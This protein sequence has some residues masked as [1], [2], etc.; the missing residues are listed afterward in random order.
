[1]AMT[2]AIL[3]DNADIADMQIYQQAGKIASLWWEGF[4][5]MKYWLRVGSRQRLMAGYIRAY[6]YNDETDAVEVVKVKEN[7]LHKWDARKQTLQM[8]CDRLGVKNPDNYFG[9]ER[10]RAVKGG[11][12][13]DATAISCLLRNAKVGDS[14]EVLLSYYYHA[15]EIRA[16][17]KVYKQKLK[18]NHV[19]RNTVRRK[20]GTVI[21]YI[22]GLDNIRMDSIKSLAVIHV[23]YSLTS[24]LPHEKLMAALAT[25]IKDIVRHAVSVFSKR[26][27]FQNIDIPLNFFEVSNCIVTADHRLCF[28]FDIKKKIRDALY[29]QQESGYDYEYEN[30]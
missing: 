16:S 20:D 14:I 15:N 8:L 22:T 26:K 12:A 5:G 21:D 17:E 7:E 18:E 25:D 30:V 10:R 2:K 19:K 28:T 11:V 1:M 24:Q 13:A 6:Y 27:Q 4:S 29:S 9:E 23:E 3:A